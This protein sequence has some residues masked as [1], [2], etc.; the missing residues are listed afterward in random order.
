[1][2]DRKDAYQERLELLGRIDRWME[3]PMLVL[4]FVWLGLLV[5]DFVYG[6]HRGL[7]VAT[8]AVWLVFL[9]HFSVEFVLAPRKLRYLREHWLTAVSLVVPALRIARLA[10]LVRMLRAA[11]GLRL[12][13]VVGSLNRGMRALGATMARRGFGYV[14]VLTLLVT[15]VGAAG[16]YALEPRESMGWR[17]YGD[18]LWWTAMLMTTMGSE[19]WPR[20][21]EARLLCFLMSVYAFAMFGYVTATLATFFIGRDAEQDQAG[22]AGHEDLQ[23]VR[24]ELKNLRIELAAM[25]QG[26]RGE[27]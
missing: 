1:M 11:R 24:D 16:M 6:P 18:A 8:T 25:R 14:S 4:A 21:P 7:D 26:R 15:L 22:R 17:S 2:L 3:A 20:S 9:L 10:P 23:A 13:K 19:Y 27:P 5:M 12:I